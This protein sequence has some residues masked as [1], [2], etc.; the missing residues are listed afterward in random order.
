MQC[1]YV[2]GSSNGSVVG[3]GERGEE[4][5]GPSSREHTGVEWLLGQL[6][7]GWVVGSRHQIN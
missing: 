4:T 7:V 6:V 1:T 2:H 3:V 5:R